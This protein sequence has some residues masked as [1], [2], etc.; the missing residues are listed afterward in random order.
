MNIQHLSAHALADYYLSLNGYQEAIKFYKKSLIEFPYSVSSGTTY[1][2][3]SERILYDIHKTYYKAEMKDEAF[4]YLLGLMISSNN[5]QETATKKMNEYLEKEDRKKFKKEVDE[6]LK[7]I[8]LF[9]KEKYLYTFTFR[10]KEILFDPFLMYSLKET[11]DAFRD[12]EFYK[13]L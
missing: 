3:D 8:Q 13:N 1:S 11:L 2:K 9:D 7:T 6:A 4:G 5:F 12:S 10:K